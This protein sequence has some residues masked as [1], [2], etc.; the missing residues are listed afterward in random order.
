MVSKINGSFITHDRPIR[1]IEKP[2][3]FTVNSFPNQVSSQY[4]TTYHP[5][6][7]SYKP[8]LYNIDFNLFKSSYNSH[9]HKHF[10][11]H[12]LQKIGVTRNRIVFNKN[13][14]Y[15]LKNSFFPYPYPSEMRIP[16]MTTN[17]NQ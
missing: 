1:Y 11:I 4:I 14:Y 9:L 16:D 15:Q 7:T 2:T 5:K 17:N 13:G 12:H 3:L 6:F 10:F 8:D